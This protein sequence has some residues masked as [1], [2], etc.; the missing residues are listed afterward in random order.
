MAKIIKM[1]GISENWSEIECRR[2]DLAD[3]NQHAA[4]TFHLSAGAIAPPRRLAAAE[5]TYAWRGEVD[6]S[7]VLS[8]ANGEAGI[9]TI[10]CATCGEPCTEDQFARIDFN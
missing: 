1:Q 2:C 3:A 10:E 5:V 9:D 8:C 4:F 6:D 7:G